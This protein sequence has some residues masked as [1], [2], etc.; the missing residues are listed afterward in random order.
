ML[1]HVENCRAWWRTPL[2]PALGRQRQADFW[3]RG[4]PGLQ[5]EF[6][7]SQGY[8]EKPC[9]KKQTNKQTNQNQN[10]NKNKNKTKTRGK[11]LTCFPKLF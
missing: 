5:S 2:I 8:T 6:Q 7:D 4:Q 1:N 3:V 9:L 10:Q 11:L